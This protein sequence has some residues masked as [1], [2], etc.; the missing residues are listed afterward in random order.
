MDK[1]RDWWI[2]ILLYQKW[3]Q[4]RPIWWRSFQWFNEKFHNYRLFCY[5]ATSLNEDS[6]IILNVILCAFDYAFEAQCVLLRTC[7]QNNWILLIF[8]L[9]DGMGNTDATQAGTK[10]TGPSCSSYEVRAWYLHRRNQAGEGWGPF[11]YFALIGQKHFQLGVRSLSMQ[12]Y[13]L[14]LTLSLRQRICERPGHTINRHHTFFSSWHEWFFH[15]KWDR[16]NVIQE[17]K[18]TWW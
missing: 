17:L 2:H 8:S 10:K 4:S 9:N 5:I 11:L 3:N 15:I 13:E 16:V 1:V 6:Y 7:V 18:R 12:G 14:P